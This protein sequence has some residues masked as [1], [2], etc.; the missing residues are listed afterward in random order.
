VPTEKAGLAG[1]ELR[2]GDIMPYR[3]AQCLRR[4]AGARV[5]HFLGVRPVPSARRGGAG[6]GRAA[7]VVVSPPTSVSARRHGH[8]RLGF[9][10]E[11]VAGW[12]AEADPTS[13][14]ATGAG[15]AQRRAALTVSLWLAQDPA[16]SPTGVRQQHREVA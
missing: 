3:W 5:L 10:R 7:L 11:Q 6:A 16:S 8:R 2:Q 4:G 1:V 15:R 14:S 9:A 13:W 12:F